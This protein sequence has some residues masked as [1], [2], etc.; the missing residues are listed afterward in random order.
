[1]DGVGVGPAAQIPLHGCKARARELPGSF[2]QPL[3]KLRSSRKQ[4]ILH[5]WRVQVGQCICVAEDYP[6][7]HK[8]IRTFQSE[9]PN[10]APR[11]LT[12]RGGRNA[13]TKG[14]FL[15]LDGT[16]FSVRKYHWRASDIAL[17][18]SELRLQDD[19]PQ[20]PARSWDLNER[21]HGLLPSAGDATGKGEFVGLR[22]TKDAW[23]AR[24]DWPFSPDALVPLKNVQGVHFIHRFTSGQF[25]CLF[26]FFF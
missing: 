5:L 9:N 12:T 13:G 24:W 1:M 6:A 25:F 23:G 2:F 10:C 21:S 17:A 3:R 14:H 16:T 11:D 7:G 20:D 19:I 8:S 4:L 18:P 22:G 15:S 26:F